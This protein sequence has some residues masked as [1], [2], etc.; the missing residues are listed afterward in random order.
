M[1]ENNSGDL[2][3]IQVP[4]YIS[5]VGIARSKDNFVKTVLS[6]RKM[7]IVFDNSFAGLVIGF[8]Q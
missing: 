6:P 2:L 5:G 8:R 4:L 7:K 1:S 3:Q